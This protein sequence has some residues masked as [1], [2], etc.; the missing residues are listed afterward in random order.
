MGPIMLDINNYNTLAD[1]WIGSTL[2]EI[3]DYNCKEVA[4]SFFQETPNGISPS[5]TKTYKETWISEIPK[6][7]FFTV[8]RVNYDV[9]SRKLVKNNK[10]FEFDKQIFVDKFLLENRSKDEEINAQI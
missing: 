5:K 6:V 4:A 9:K 7:L 2:E 10:K 8:Q 1:A 3:E